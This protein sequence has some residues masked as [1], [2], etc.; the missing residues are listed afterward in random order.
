[1]ILPSQEYKMKF[2]FQKKKKKLTRMPHQT[3][4]GKP[5]KLKFWNTLKE[6]HIYLSLGTIHNNIR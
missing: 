5:H 6:M 1:M 2:S 4:I 3:V